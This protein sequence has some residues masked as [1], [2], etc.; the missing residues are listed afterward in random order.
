MNKLTL[1]VILFLFSSFIYGQSIKGT[2]YRGNSDTTVADAIVYYSGS[3]NGNSLTDEKGQFELIAK[4]TQIPIVASCVG[5]YSTTVFYKPNEPLIIRLTPKQE[6]LK[7]VVIS[8]NGVKREDEVAMFLKDFLGTSK[9]AKSCIISNIDDLDFSYNKKTQVLKANCYKP[10]IIENKKLG[11]TISYYLDKFE[12]SPKT[13]SIAGYYLFKDNILPADKNFAEIQKNRENAYHG[14]RMQFIRALWH[15]DLDK[16]AFEIYNQ[17]YK[18]LVQDSIVVQDS[19]RQKYIHLTGRTYLSNLDEDNTAPNPFEQKE[20]YTFID[21]DGYWGDGLVW[22]GTMGVQ[23]MGD[24]LPFDFQSTAEI[25]DDAQHAGT[26]LTK[27]DTSNNI[28]NLLNTVAKY[29][30]TLSPEKLYLNFDKPYYAAGDTAWFKAYVL[31]DNGRAPSD[32][33]AKLYV[34]L[35]GN[36]SKLAQRLVLP[37]F[38]GLA[39]GYIS[40]D[41]KTV[42]QGSYTIRAYTNWL[43]NFGGGYFFYKQLSVGEP[44]GKTWLV[45]EQHQVDAGPDSNH[46]TLAMRFTDTKGLPLVARQLSVKILDGT[47]TILKSDITTGV[48]GALNSKLILPSKANKHN[49]SIQVDDAADKAQHIAFPFYPSGA[50]GD[51]DL[52]FMPEGGNLVAGL[53]NRVAFKAIGEDGLSREIKGTIVDSKGTEAA[54]LQ[55]IYSG[56]GSFVLVPSAGETYTAKTIV[57]G[58][59]KTYVLPVAK[60]QGI[61]LRV[62]ATNHADELYVYISATIADRP[63]YT[64]I[65]QA[66]GEVYFGSSFTLNGEG[67]FNTHILKSKFPTGI[68]SLIILGTDN[69]PVAQR[70]VF[71]NHHDSL[72][73]TALPGQPAYSPHDSI[74]VNLQAMNRDGKPAQGSF[75][76]SVTDDAQVKDAVQPDNIQSHIL[77]ASELKGNIENPAWYFEKGDE[78]L[79]E[80]ALDNLLLTQG[81]Q[82]FDWDKLNKPLPEPAYAVEPNNNV[83]GSLKNILGKPAAGLKVL[84]LANGKQSFLKDTLSDKQGKFA[85]RNLPLT[86]TVAYTIKL[87]NSKDK[88]AATGIIVDEFKPVTLKLPVLP[89][90]QPL[91]LNA[92]STLL[93]YMH[94]S[95]QR[96]QADALFTP[97]DGTKLLNQVNIAAKRNVQEVNNEFATEVDS[98]SAATLIAANKMTLMDL[99]YRELKGTL[100]ETELYAIRSAGDTYIQGKPQHYDRVKMRNTQQFVVGNT[101]INDFIVDGQ[102]LGELTLSLRDIVIEPIDPKKTRWGIDADA[103]DNDFFQR[104]SGLLNMLSAEDVKSIRVFRGAFITVLITTRSGAGLTAVPSYGTYAYRPLPMQLPKQFYSP[105]YNVKNTRPDVRSTIHWEPNLVTDEKGNAKLSFYAAD[106]PGTYT[107]AIEG[108]DMQGHFGVSTTKIKIV[109]K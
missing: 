27:P 30:A 94:H 4:S 76:V 98:I 23:R 41:A 33:S 21:K 5:Y 89:R 95:T 49:L 54:T 107:V 74:S 45:T 38:D 31:A 16:T 26:I 10:I 88:S 1:S 83:S 72:Q 70:S 78:K 86:D 58:K 32:K 22:S 82:G 96:D 64:L 47:K 42:T 69:K 8:G 53:Y 90:L 108:T 106:K 43:Q 13:I 60:Q 65:A 15:H 101:R 79:K 102:S 51:I 24:L 109:G 39:Q 35:L 99:L 9:Y 29:N 37:V 7:E 14:S 6:I 92:D 20:K 63:K 85:F 81:W 80:K 67:F 55:S 61:A 97:T 46:L 57:N 103:A 91:N 84:L 48:D 100:K 25:T 44:G 87:H 66:R 34:E 12:K 93:N 28:K 62:D 52:Q 40:L 19:S 75:S 71:I 73:L 18:K 105:K 3:A 17:S 50:G 2:I 36:D 77:L 56:M 11:Y 68:V 59:E 104:A